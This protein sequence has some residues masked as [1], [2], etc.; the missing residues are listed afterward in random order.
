MPSLMNYFCTTVLFL[1]FAFAIF[2]WLMYIDLHEFRHITILC[3]LFH[4]VL[5]FRMPNQ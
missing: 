1:A 4:E 5:K 3:V 2:D